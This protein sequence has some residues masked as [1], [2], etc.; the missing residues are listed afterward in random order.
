M[1]HDLLLRLFSLTLTSSIALLV[2]LPLRP[3]IRRHAGPVPAYASWLLL[4]LSLL[5]STLPNPTSHVPV[6]KAHVSVVAIAHAMPEMTRGGAQMDASG[7]LLAWSMGAAAVAALLTWQQ[8]RFQR[9][10][11][12]LR[13]TGIQHVYRAEGSDALG[14]LLLGFLRPK[15]VLPADFAKRYSPD[16]QQ[17][18]LAHERVHLQR[19][20]MLANGMV[21]I[22]Q[23][24][25][26]FNPL[27]HFAVGRFRLDQE[28]ACDA[29]VLRRHPQ[30]RQVYAEAI[31]KTQLNAAGVPFG[32]QWQ[33][34][35]P[36]KERLLQLSRRQPHPARRASVMT[37]LAGLI[38]V[39]CYGAWANEHA[40]RASAQNQR[41]RFKVML[42]MTKELGSTAAGPSKSTLTVE[43]PTISGIRVELGGN[44]HLM[45]WGCDLLSLDVREWQKDTVEFSL[46]FRCAE[47]GEQEPK[48][49]V[50]LGEPA[51]VQMGV[52]DQ[53]IYTFV[54]AV[55]R[56]PT[57]TPWPT[58]VPFDQLPGWAQRTQQ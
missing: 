6:I 28:L 34:G 55:D 8:L 30:S 50:R 46:P 56:W 16:E 14:P 21:A 33:S 49:R 11:G 19:G 54:V 36:L 44:P 4:P 7:W 57:T 52:K 3:L 39:A 31:F 10:L 18:I 22:L 51:T 58:P 32:C 15:I 29:T 35:H 12:R 38:S 17:L 20:D 1:S 40:P 5:A 42:S 37:L 13:A 25:L 45:S 47:T 2:L 23:V 9:S 27:L 43:V 26:W 53:Y 24:L 48:L 41:E